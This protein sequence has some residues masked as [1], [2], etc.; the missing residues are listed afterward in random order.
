MVRWFS[1]QTMLEEAESDVLILLDC[2][3]VA[4]SAR[5]SGKG[6]TEV[7]AACGFET[8]APSVSEHSFTRSLI[9]KLE[10]LG[11]SP[12]FSAAL[13]HNKVLSQIKYWKHR[14]G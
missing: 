6:I 10:Y 4:S 8:W 13:L 5:G 3:A 7:I 2:C 9:S 11:S 14:F 1:L 12:P